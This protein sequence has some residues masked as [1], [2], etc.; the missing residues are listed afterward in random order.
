MI[1]INLLKRK[2]VYSNNRD[3]FSA[4]DNNFDKMVDDKIESSKVDEVIDDNFESNYNKRSNKANKSNSRKLIIILLFL[5]TISAGYYYFQFYMP[6]SY[7]IG[8]SHIKEL[9][10]YTLD[11]EDISIENIEF[12]NNNLE[13]I[14]KISPA[15]FNEYK[16]KIGKYFDKM[17]ASAHF[18]Y[19]L[20][21]QLLSIKSSDKITIVND[22]FN[23][24]TSI[25]ELKSASIS[26]IDKDGLKKA[27][28]S[29]F[30]INNASLIDFNISPS[31]DLSYSLYNILL[32]E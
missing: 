21:N 1:D 25:Q 26:D 6:T 17:N 18:N 14:L 30:N 19:M 31:S 5:L 8:S 24:M 13:F 15:S 29:I 3:D 32:S 27:V 28:D 4:I 16:V 22:K 23:Q 11:N 7:Q 9:I 2:G 20:S 12:N 10:F